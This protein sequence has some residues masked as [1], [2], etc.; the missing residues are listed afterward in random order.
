[1][2][3]ATPKPPGQRR[4]RNAD[5]A[6]WRSLPAAGRDGKV[7]ALPGASKLG[8]TARDWWATVWTSPMSN[9]YLAADIPALTR[10]AGLVAKAASGEASGTE[11]GE[12]RQLEDRFGL[13][14]LARRRLQWEIERADDRP[15]PVPVSNDREARLRLEEG[16][17]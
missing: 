16:K 8:K 7:P 9:V 15:A 2:T 11:L 4:R 6:A 14:P 5:Q 3:P 12:L 1:M 17:R 13:S 10:A